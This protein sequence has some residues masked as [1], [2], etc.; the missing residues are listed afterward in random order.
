MA[1]IKISIN[2]LDDA[3]TKLKSLKESCSSFDTKF[4]DIIGGGSTVNELENI[5]NT[6]KNMNTDFLT[7]ISNTISFMENVK[8]S[9]VTSD[10]KAAA[11]ISFKE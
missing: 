6:Y 7:L 11:G 3:I 4:P 8:S 1:E 5:A 9:Y 10:A 2:A